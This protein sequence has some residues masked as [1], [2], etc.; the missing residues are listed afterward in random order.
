M[1]EVRAQVGLVFNFVG[2]PPGRERDDVGD[3][4]GVEH[5]TLRGVDLDGVAEVDGGDAGGAVLGEEGALLL[6]V[7]VASRSR[8]ESGLLVERISVAVIHL[9]FF[10]LGFFLF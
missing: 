3:G 10:V 6:L 8:K 5:V 2:L 9:L 1:N 7:V 4:D